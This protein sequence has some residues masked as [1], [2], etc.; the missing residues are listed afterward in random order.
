MYLLGFKAVQSRRDKKEAWA[1]EPIL[2][3]RKQMLMS[4]IRFAVPITIGSCF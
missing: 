3:S 4:L 1:E 2:T